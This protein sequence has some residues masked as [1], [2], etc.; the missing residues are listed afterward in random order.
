MA[1]AGGRLVHFS[2]RLPTTTRAQLFE[3]AATSGRPIAQLVRHAAQSHL[4]GA[5]AGAT[6]KQPHESEHPED[7]LQVI[8]TRL[9]LDMLEA[10]RAIAAARN[11][12]A[13]DEMRDA[14]QGWLNSV[15]PAV[16]GTL[17]EEVPDGTH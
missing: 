6:R 16:L 7:V 1:A 2:F 14:I 4:D 12:T 9:P 8:S 5:S 17:P 13:S 15:D 11:R 10:I 3:V